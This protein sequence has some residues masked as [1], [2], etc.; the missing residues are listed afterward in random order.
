MVFQE[1]KPRYLYLQG[2]PF[3]LEDNYFRNGYGDRKLDDT[4]IKRRKSYLNPN[5]YQSHFDLG[6]LNQI[7][8]GL[9]FILGKCD[10][11]TK[12]PMRPGGLTSTS[13]VFLFP[14]SPYFT[15]IPHD[16]CYSELQL[17]FLP[18]PLI[19]NTMSLFPFFSH[20]DP[21]RQ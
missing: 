11:L 4:F 21:L 18:Y 1:I 2:N 20:I 17:S 3:S 10:F 5:I 13:S 7:G 6:V 8:I 9:Y 19:Q 12:I 16:T 15:T 14:Y